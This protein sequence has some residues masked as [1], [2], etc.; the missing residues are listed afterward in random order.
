MEIFEDKGNARVRRTGTCG[1]KLTLRIG[2][3]DEREY[4]ARSSGIPLRS[5][6]LPYSTRADEHS[7]PLRQ[8][9]E[10]RT[11]TY[12]LRACVRDGEDARA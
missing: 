2:Q 3:G 9:E 8:G 6:V 5:I 12:R 4:K 1:W 10:S 7:T 11:E